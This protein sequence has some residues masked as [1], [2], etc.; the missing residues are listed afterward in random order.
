MPSIKS[1]LLAAATA[2]SAASAAYT[3]ETYNFKAFDIVKL[4]AVSFTKFTETVM[5]GGKPGVVLTTPTHINYFEKNEVL[6][7]SITLPEDGE[8]QFIAA[9]AV[10]AGVVQVSMQLSGSPAADLINLPTTGDFITAAPSF[11]APF[12]AKAGTYTLTVKNTSP[13]PAIYSNLFW[14][15]AAK[16]PSLTVGADGFYHIR[17]EAEDYTAAITETSLVGPFGNKG[18]V[19]RYTNVDVCAN[20][21]PL[22][23]YQL[24]FFDPNESVS[25][26]VEIPADDEYTLN[27]S[28]ASGKV[29][30]S[31]TVEIT[32]A[33]VASKNDVAVNTLNWQGF[34]T[35]SFP[36][37]LALK[38]GKHTV[39]LTVK[40][41]TTG[42][43]VDYFEFVGSTPAVFLGAPTTTVATTAAATE[44]ATEAPSDAFTDAPTEAVTD[45]PTEAVTDVATT[46]EVVTD[47]PTEAIT[48]APTEEEGSVDTTV[49]P[50]LRAS[51]PVNA[52]GVF[53][54]SFVLQLAIVA[55]AAMLF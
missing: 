40:S 54:A 52:S 8:Y 2:V 10:K 51:A 24:C 45:A 36:A 27:L 16:I 31:V 43:N 50:T 7:Y 55:A 6:T 1:A 46:E 19:Y 14:V 34:Q 29:A 17:R 15:G 28:M 21:A 13:L 38:K 35:Q 22:S 44:A 33:G 53:S 41:A 5:H 3:T 32:G 39:K 49:K 20:L 4:D 37:P 9:A 47:A 12:S 25:Y 42:A 26:D 23:G 11:G 18:A 48:D 30:A